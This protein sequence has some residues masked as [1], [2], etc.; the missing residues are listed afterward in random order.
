M[1]LQQTVPLVML[2]RL[3]SGFVRML[4]SR[5]SEGL[6]AQFSHIT[7]L[8][9]ELSLLYDEHIHRY[10]SLRTPDKEDPTISPCST[11]LCY[12]GSLRSS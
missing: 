5:G 10:P 4:Q 8:T 6:Q 7:I 9:F 12:V 3:L 11:F 1:R 2:I